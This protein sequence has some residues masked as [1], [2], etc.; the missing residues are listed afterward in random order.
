[1]SQLQQN[2]ET[3]NTATYIKACP[4]GTTRYVLRLGETLS[5]VARQFNITLYQLLAANP[6]INPNSYGAGTVVCVPIPT[7]PLDCPSGRFHQ[8]SFG[9][10]AASIANLYQISETALRQ[11]NPLIAQY[12]LIP[13]QLLCIP[14]APIA[15]CPGGGERVTL[16]AGQSFADVLV[17]RNVS[18]RALQSSNP[19]VN[20]AGLGAGQSVCVPSRGSRGTCRDCT[21]T[22]I[23]GPGETLT[24][25]ARSQNRS[26]GQLLSYNPTMLPSDF[27]AGQTICL[28]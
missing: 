13:G 4:L 6:D 11:A 20:I 26:I 27:A 14:S 15:A 9:E 5:N 16:S 12:G 7:E 18:Y 28:T 22:Y 10:T 25:V 2:Q 23:M 3:V 8:V 24:S 21:M 17:S 1:M 19:G